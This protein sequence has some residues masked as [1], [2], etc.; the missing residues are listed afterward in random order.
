L[1]NK[2]LKNDEIN[3]VDPVVLEV[4][5]INGTL[6]ENESNDE[7]NGLIEE[8]IDKELILNEARNNANTILEEAKLEAN[9]ILAEAKKEAERIRLK[10]EETARKTGY[11]DGFARA[12]KEHKKIIEEAANIKKKAEDDYMNTINNIEK[13]VIEIIYNIIEKILGYEIEEDDYIISLINN[14]VKKTNTKKDIIV[15]VSESDFSYVSKNIDRIYAINEGLGEIKIEVDKSISRGGLLLE[16]PV[17]NI[18]ASVYKQYE[19]LKEVFNEIIMEN[20]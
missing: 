17:G 8:T 12:Q 19:K 14:S 20:I 16:T 11:D 13:D 2:V 3:I 10:I 7:E 5:K 6:H 4:E 18:D 1:Y 15:K 9:E